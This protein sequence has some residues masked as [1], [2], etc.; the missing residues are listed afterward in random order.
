MIKTKSLIMQL[1]K[2]SEKLSL[3]SKDVFDDIVVYVRTSNIKTRDAEEFLQQILDSFLNAEQQGVSIENVLGTTDIKHYCE[4]IVNTYKSNYHYSSLCSEYVMYT[5][6]IITI[7]SI[8]NYITQSVTIISKY[9]VNNLTFY[10]NL[11]LG[12]IS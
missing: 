4:E 11:N 7:L 8:F 12:I 1:N 9:G 6:M 2:A 10:L 3:E 5:G